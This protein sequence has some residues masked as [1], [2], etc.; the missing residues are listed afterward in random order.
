MIVIEKIN[1]IISKFQKRIMTIINNI[2]MSQNN[3]S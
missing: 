1:Y 3:Y 2:K